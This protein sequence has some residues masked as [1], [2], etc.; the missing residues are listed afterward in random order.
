M[1][2]NE[3]KREQL[4]NELSELRSQNAAQEKAIT[5]YISA[6]LAAEETLRY[7]ESIVETVREPLLVLEADLKI[8]SA[9]LYDGE[10]VAVC[11]RL[12][13]EKQFSFE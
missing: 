9:I 7:A 1:K 5:G 10:A 3:K 11:S 12:F 8:I 2:D 13:R 6:E 4:V